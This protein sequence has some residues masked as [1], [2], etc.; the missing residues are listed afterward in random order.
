MNI[1]LEKKTWGDDLREVFYSK[2]FGHIDG[3]EWMMS[4]KSLE[5]LKTFITELLRKQNCDAMLDILNDIKDFPYS[6]SQL[7]PWNHI[8][9]EINKK[10]KEIEILNA[11]E[12]G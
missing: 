8:L 5:I 9:V 1:E 4:D 7:V 10:I 3:H 2:E 12:P 11:K 6:K